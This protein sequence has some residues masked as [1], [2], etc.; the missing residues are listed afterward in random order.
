MNVRARTSMLASI[1]I[2]ASFML[3]PIS[4]ALGASYSNYFNVGTN[5]ALAVG[6]AQASIPQELHQFAAVVIQDLSQHQPFTHWK[7]AE[8]VIEP[9]GPGT[10]SWLVTILDQEG[11]TKGSTSGYLIIS[12]TASGEYKLIEYGIGPDSIYAKSTLENALS[13][14][15]IHSNKW[16]IIP[17]YSGPVLA[18][19]TIRTKGATQHGLYW[20]AV[21]GELLPENEASWNIQAPSYIPPD[22]ALGNKGID[23]IGHTT[24]T[25]SEPFVHSADSFDPYDNMLWITGQAINVNQ[26]SF[27]NIIKKKKRLV[28]V[29]TGDNRTYSIPLPIYGYQKWSNKAGSTLYLMSGTTSSLRF[30][31]VQALIDSGHFINYE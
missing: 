28:F 25:I 22:S 20:D 5:T 6:N 13:E 4:N 8:P 23:Q 15:G 16:D 11:N 18:E 2:C 3:A 17:L 29:T 27:E 14:S 31:A 30:I 24:T 9:L 26:E 10:H 1:F 7:G 12:V 21:T 19:W